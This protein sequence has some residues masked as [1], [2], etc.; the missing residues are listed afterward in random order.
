MSPEQAELSGVDIDTRSDI[1]SPGRVALR[2]ADRHDALR[3]ARRFARRPS[4]RV[5]RIIREEEP[6]RPSTRLS[7]LGDDSDDRLGRAQG[8]PAAAGAVACAA[9]STGS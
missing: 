7:T 9:S 8:R 1:Y 4:T 2:A 3:R 5:R 6:P